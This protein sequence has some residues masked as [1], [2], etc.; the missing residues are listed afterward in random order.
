MGEIALK[1]A[2]PPTTSVHFKGS[3]AK[4]LM[5]SQEA[6]Q[7]SKSPNAPPII[8]YRW[9]LAIFLF[10]IATLFY[11][12]P[13]AFATLFPLLRGDLGFSELGSVFKEHAQLVAGI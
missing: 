7:S 4:E 2:T 5:N 13:T 3:P 10:L 11:S 9:V 12:D 8:P 6:N 1:G